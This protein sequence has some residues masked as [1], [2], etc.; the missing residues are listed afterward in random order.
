MEEAPAPREDGSASPMD[1]IL[2][3]AR[4]HREHEKYYSVAPLRD[5][6]VLARAS[7]TLKALA[8]RWSRIEVHLGNR[9]AVPH[10]GCEDLND[11][12]A[13][14]TLGV[15]FME[16]M[17]EP[18][19]LVRLRADLRTRGAGAEQTG[20]WLRNAMASSWK[21]AG[22]LLG[23]RPLAD[24]LGDRHRIIANNRLAAEMSCLV[25]AL[26][27]RAAEI[28]ETVDLSP[29]GLRADLST[30][31]SVPGYLY[32]AAALLDRAIDLSAIST[33]LSRDSEP[34]WR[35]WSQRAEEIH[36]SSAA[37]LTHSQ[38]APPESSD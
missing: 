17:G 31:R 34:A 38:K 14:E 27:L 32:S 33:A 20:A 22:A 30:D 2:N 16:G 36:Q 18:A 26:L 9:S 15:L 35:A 23:M 37:R 21:S 3:L 4:Y 19:E 1:A 11:Q 13:I 28:L 25:A 12:T 6:E 8:D 10:T 24:V 29:N 5:A 7:L